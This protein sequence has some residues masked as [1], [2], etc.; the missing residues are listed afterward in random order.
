MGWIH[1]DCPSATKIGGWM[2]MGYHDQSND[3]F[4]DRPDKYALHQGWLYAEKVPDGCSSYFGFR[5][6]LMYGID[7]NDT[8]AFGN[9]LGSWDFANGFDYGAYGW[10]IPQAY[11]E[12]AIGNWSV[13]TGHFFTLMGYEVV[14]APGNFFYSHAMTMYNSEPFTH[15]GVLAT[16]RVGDKLELHAGWTLGWDTGFDVLNDGDSWLGGLSYAVGDNASLTYIAMAGNFGARG[17]DGY[18]HSVILN[19]TLTDRLDWVVQSDL[20][21]VDSTAEDNV[22]VNQYFLYTINDCLKLGS[23]VEWWKADGISGY[24]P[25]GANVPLNESLS[26]YAATFGANIRPHPNWVFRPEVRV[27]WSP[28]ANY[29]EVYFG[30]DAV[31]TF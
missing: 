10:A 27:D 5:A 20:L 3:L 14:A 12:V 15:T 24:A 2:S 26:Y 29:D 8:Q 28:A 22:G 11:I 23:R 7:A 1:G 19:F 25:H 31:M 13:K 18:A 6:D 21:R 16:R 17:D 9:P 30:I 4:N